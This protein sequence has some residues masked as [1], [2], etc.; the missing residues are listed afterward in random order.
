MRRTI[1]LFAAFA[2]VAG[3]SAC[4]S[5]STPEA[6][7]PAT[8]RPTVPVP[9]STGPPEPSPATSG[10]RGFPAETLTCPE[11]RPA[12]PEGLPIAITG[13]V[14]SYVVC[15]PY[16]GDPPVQQGK[17]RTL[18]SEAELKALTAALSVPSEIAPP[19]SP[20]ACAAY[21]NL[22]VLILV[23]TAD[24]TWTASV[25][26]DGCSHYYPDLLQAIGPSAG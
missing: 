9:S 12:E 14:Q 2:L 18:T 11:Q 1:T 8:Q 13:E 21:A 5:G 3:L 17:P 22:P 23:K 20:T 24:G 6:A 26:R 25:P 7:A 16:F 10:L 19:A 4:T 15:P